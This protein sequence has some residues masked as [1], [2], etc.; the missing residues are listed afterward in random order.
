MWIAFIKSIYNQYEHLYKYVK[1]TRG[2]SHGRFNVENEVIRMCRAGRPD[3]K[4][5]F[6]C[7]SCGRV[8]MDGIQ[9]KRTREKYHVKDLYCLYERKDSKAVEVRWCDSID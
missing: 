1:N 2:F 9:R 3:R 7:L 4:S 5:K 8:I 6:I